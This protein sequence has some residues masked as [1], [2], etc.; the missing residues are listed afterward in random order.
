MEKQNKKWKKNLK[1]V[2]SGTNFRIYDEDRNR[3]VSNQTFT[4]VFHAKQY[5]N[6]LNNE[7]DY[8]NFKSKLNKIKKDK[9]LTIR[10]KMRRY[11]LLCHQAPDYS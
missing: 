1:I 4:D 7:L 3:M 11:K 9:N 6:S 2:R 5:I 10:Q 8:N